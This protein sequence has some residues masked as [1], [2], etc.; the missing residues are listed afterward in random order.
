MSNNPTVE[1]RRRW[2]R[3]QALGCIICGAAASIHH[4]GTGAGGRKNHDAVLPLCFKH[5][6]NGTPEDPSIHPW[7]K[8]FEE[9]YGAENELLEKLERLLCANAPHV[10]LSA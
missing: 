7:R 10:G 8:R 1:Q 5:H 2:S 6:Q 3:I 4:C 9:K